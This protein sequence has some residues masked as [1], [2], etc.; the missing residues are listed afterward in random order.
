MFLKHV[1]FNNQAFRFSLV[2]RA[3]SKASSSVLISEQKT[4]VGNFEI[5]YVKSFIENGNPK[6]TLVCLPGALG[7][8]VLRRN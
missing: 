5:N 4:K 7:L 6:S 2:N 8:I 3:F 1:T